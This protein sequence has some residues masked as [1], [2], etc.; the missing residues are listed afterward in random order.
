MPG[1]S[2]P[3]VLVPR[4]T[5]YLGAGEYRTMPVPVAAYDR[6]ILNFLC[7]PLI[8]AGSTGGCVCEESNDAQL[9]TGCSGS[10]PVLPASFVEVQWTF[11][12]TK[13]WMRF[14]VNLT[15]TAP[16]ITCY[17]QGFFELRER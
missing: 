3:V 13:A 5:T 8:G 6:L 12:L 11:D 1:K 17:A 4:F 7:G 14:A 16:G 10:T 2:V 9:W 15:G